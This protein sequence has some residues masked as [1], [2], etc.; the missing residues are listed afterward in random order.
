ML[1]PATGITP[2]KALNLVR[3]LYPL[4]SKETMSQVPGPES[5]L[6]RVVQIPFTHQE[7]QVPY[8]GEASFDA[9]SSISR[10]QR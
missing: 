7:H 4:E 3:T 10:D 9:L 5:T 2:Q 8:P 6:H 1:V